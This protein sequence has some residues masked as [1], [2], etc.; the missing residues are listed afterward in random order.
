MYAVT[1]FP[2]V[3]GMETGLSPPSERIQFNISGKNSED[4]RFMVYY[5]VN[6]Q[7]KNNSSTCF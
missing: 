1:E 7:C 2:T 4:F 5:Y 6:V 3:A